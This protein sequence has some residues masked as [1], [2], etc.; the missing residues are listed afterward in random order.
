MDT[1]KENLKQ[2]MKRENYSITAQTLRSMTMDWTRRKMVEWSSQLMYVE[3]LHSLTQAIAAL[4]ISCLLPPWP[5]K[6]FR[7]LSRNSFCRHNRKGKESLCECWSQYLLCVCLCVFFPPT[8]LA[9]L[10]ST[11]SLEM[12]C[13]ISGQRMRRMICRGHTAAFLLALSAK[14]S[15]RSNNFS[16]ASEHRPTHTELMAT[17]SHSKAILWNIQ[18]IISTTEKLFTK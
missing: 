8:L 1:K 3:A 18:R 16:A 5:A 10:S 6:A 17:T 9:L 13:V 2:N 14:L 4:S 11:V 15:T 7:K 12:V